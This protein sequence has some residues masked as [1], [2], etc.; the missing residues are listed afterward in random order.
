MIYSSNNN[1]LVYAMKKIILSAIIILFVCTFPIRA[2]SKKNDTLFVATWNMENLF[3]TVHDPGKRDEEFTPASKKHWTKERL[4]LKL[5]HLASVIKLMN[6]GKGPDI[7]GVT[8]VEHKAILE[9]MIKKYLPGRH[10]MVAYRESPDERGIDNGLIYNS[11]KLKLISVIGDTI[12]LKEDFPTRL[13]LNANFLLGKDTLRFFENHW[14]ARIGGVEKTEPYRIEAAAVLRS[15][16]DSYLSANK[17][18][19]LIMMGDFNDVPNNI[20]IEKTLG[21]DSAACSPNEKNSKSELFNLAYKDFSEGLG[22]Y[23]YRDTWDMIDQIIVSKDLLDGN[24]IDYVCGSFKIFKP[25][26]MITKSGEYAGTPF[27][28]YGGNHYLGG[29]SDH[30]PV[31]AKFV[32]VGK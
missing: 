8:E 32:V 17:S 27:P 2:K 29:Y 10:Y 28:T 9:M 14:P 23:K 16:V 7:L 20:S 15:Q 11:K 26:F 5:K 12:K 19:D 1:L 21:A 22:S 6:K 13:I 24:R 30:F 31:T 3:D 25:S 18:S 4:D